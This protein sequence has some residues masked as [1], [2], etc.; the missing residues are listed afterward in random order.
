MIRDA[1]NRVVE[2]VNQQHGGVQEIDG[3][4]YYVHADSLKP[5][6]APIID[7]PFY[8]CTLTGLRDYLCENPDSID[9]SKVIVEVLSP[10]KVVVVSIPESIWGRRESY[11]ISSHNP[12]AF[13]FG[14]GHNVEEFIIGLQSFFVQDAT[15]A[16]LL[17]VVSSLVSEANVNY[18]DDG[19]SQ[20]VQA[21]TGI[22]RVANVTVPNPVTLS[23]F[24]TFTELQQP[25]SNFVFRI[26]QGD[27]GPL[28]ALHEAGGNAWEL[29]AIKLIRNWLRVELP[30]GT[31]ILA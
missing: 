11:I 12:K 27:K 21:K 19:I 14:R 22:A 26:T 7:D 23:P 15:T 13:P 4:L 18:T 3:R 24:R 28:C 6:E 2:L 16:T 25:A 10:T 8:V 31:V 1:I 9:L 29:E 5:I 20:T 30:G 17:Q